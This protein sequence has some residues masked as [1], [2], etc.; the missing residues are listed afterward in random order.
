MNTHKCA[1]GETNPQ[2]FYG[3]KTKICGTC[4]NKYTLDKGRFN[5]LKAIQYLGGQCVCCGYNKH[6]CA[7]DIHHLNPGN[8]S[9]SFSTFRG[10]SWEKIEAEIQDCI[11]L[12]KNCHSAFHSGVLE[13]DEGP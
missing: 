8:K 12:C 2:K 5:R 9:K 7:L 3:N 13:W 1:C 6:S 11:L 4:H 10:W